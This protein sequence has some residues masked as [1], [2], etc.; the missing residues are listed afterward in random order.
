M[1]FQLGFYTWKQLTMMMDD[2]EM[3]ACSRAFEDLSRNIQIEQEWKMR[4]K[5]FSV[6]F[7]AAVGF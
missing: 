7:L 3:Q 5:N 1:E 4:A 6:V 2:E